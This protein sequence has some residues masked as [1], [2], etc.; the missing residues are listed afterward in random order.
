[1]TEN[2]TIDNTTE[3]TAAVILTKEKKQNMYLALLYIV[4][5]VVIHLEE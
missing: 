3:N 5:I 4:N 1:M 2:T